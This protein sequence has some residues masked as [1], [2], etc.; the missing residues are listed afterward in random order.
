MLSLSSRAALVWAAWSIVLALPAFPSPVHAERLSHTVDVV[1]VIEPELSFTVE[2]ATGS[3]IDF[4]V[5]GNSPVE[6]QPSEPVDVAIHV[7]SNLGQRYRVTQQLIAPLADD[8]AWPL[9]S[10][11]LVVYGD[12][13]TAPDG[14]AADQP[15]VIVTSDQKGRSL[16]SS[17]AYQLLI[18]PTQ[19]AALSQGMVLMT[20]LAE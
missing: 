12:V 17:I 16:A 19:A 5:L 3:R 20:V 13:D 18:P 9:P 8:A 14:R 6:Q 1:A 2:P 10:G 4:G 15:Q 11:A 7:D